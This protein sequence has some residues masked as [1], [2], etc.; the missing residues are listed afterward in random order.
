MGFLVLITKEF[1][2]SQKRKSEDREQTDHSSLASRGKF[3]KGFRELGDIG[4]EL[5][6]QIKQA[7]LSV[8][9]FQNQSSAAWLD[10]FCHSGQAGIIWEEKSSVQKMSPSGWM[11]V[12]AFSWLMICVVSSWADGLAFYEKTN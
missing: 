1:K 11:S 4:L 5:F 2:N 7:V 10:F 9:Y 6:S 8:L 12:E 3:Q